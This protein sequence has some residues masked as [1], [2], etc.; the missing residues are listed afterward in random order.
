MAQA[1]SRLGETIGYRRRPWVGRGRRTIGSSVHRPP[2]ALH[3]P[4]PSDD[5][6]SSGS[7]AVVIYL[8]C[9]Y[10][11]N[12]VEWVGRKL[13]VGGQ[14]DGY[15]SWQ[16]SGPPCRKSVVTFVAVV[17]GKTA[18]QREIG[19]R[20]GARR[21]ACSGNDCPTRSSA[22]R[23]SFVARGLP[24]TEA[25]RRDFRKS[26]P[27]SGM[28][29]HHLCREDRAR[30][31]RVWPT[32]PGWASSSWRPTAPI[33]GKRCV[34]SRL[35]TKAAWNRSSS[36]PS[37]NAANLGRRDADRPGAG[38]HF[39]GVACIRESAG[40]RLDRRWGSGLNCWPCS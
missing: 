28:V 4:A 30:P 37:S 40:T 8:A 9:E 36:C 10:F 18:E 12:G 35:T 21:P 38:R 31:L 5:R 33:S 2:L 29:P 25:I 3:A 34:R 15:D 16:R 7:S 13:A 14:A 11:V 19:R 6:A 24:Q 22:S 26:Q 17:F 39:R 20:G 23:S 32:S 27:G 1:V